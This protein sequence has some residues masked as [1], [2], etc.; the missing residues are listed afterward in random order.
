MDTR[1]GSWSAPLA[2]PRRP[3]LGRPLRLAGVWLALV[4]AFGACSGPGPTATPTPTPAPAPSPTPSGPASS[5]PAPDPSILIDQITDQVVAIRGLTLEAPIRS[6]VLD[7]TAASQRILAQF[8]ADNP[9]DVLEPNR[10]LLVDLGLLPAGADLRAL[11][12]ELLAS[13]VAGFYDPKAKEMVVIS[14]GAGLGPTERTTY[15]HEITHALQDQHFGLEGLDI[16]AVGQGDRN[17]ARLALV[18]GDATLV[19]TYWAQQNLNQQEL[20]QLVQDA[21]DPKALAVLQRMPA[22]LRESLLFPYTAGLQFVLAIEAQQGWPGVDAAF[23]QPPSSTEQV[24]HP[25]RFGIGST[26]RDE[27]AAVTLPDGIVARLGV[28]WTKAL[29]DTAGEFLL[30]LWLAQVGG[31]DDATATAA[32][33]G[34]GGDR[35]ALYEHGDRFGVVLATSWDSAVDAAEFA[36][37]ATTLVGRL[38]HPAAVVHGA[39]SSAVTVLIAVDAATLTDLRRAAAV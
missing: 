2:V 3:A 36:D 5:T 23:Q 7:E 8:D 10:R 30:R 24:L 35:V 13:Q 27:P 34:W 38:D 33:A 25:E 39:G 17:L 26:P 18:E 22:V 20:L 6:V 29:E 21:Q 37:A 4:L 16:D 14:K 32:A 12:H 28:G 11:Y 15:A 9:P 1:R 31:L 19:M